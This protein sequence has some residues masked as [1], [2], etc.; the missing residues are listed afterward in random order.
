MDGKAQPVTIQLHPAPARP[1]AA[2]AARPAPAQ[3][4][5]IGEIAPNWVVRGWTD[6]KERSIGELRGR[7]VC[8]DFWNLRSGEL[9][10]PA[11]DR[12][13]QKFEPRGVVFLSIHT[14]DGSLDQIRKLYALKKVSLVS[15]VDAGPEDQIGEGATA[16]M[17]GVRGFPW[18]YVIDRSGKVAFNT[19]DPANQGAMVAIVQKAGDRREQAAHRGSDEPGD[20][21]LPRRGH[22]EGAG[23]TVGSLRPRGPALGELGRRPV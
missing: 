16:R 13:R 22:R 18:G 4:L 21:S 15:A 2:P 11:L 20:G 7:V 1:A 23:P 9:T 14:P 19:N 3:P 8:L 10:L 12:L 5:K 6:G 17:Y